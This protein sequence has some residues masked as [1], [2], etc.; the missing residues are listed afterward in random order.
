MQ[1]EES[2][3]SQESDVLRKEEWKSDFSK[4]SQ[5]HTDEFRRTNYIL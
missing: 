1:N 3:S 4:T 2:A 5:L